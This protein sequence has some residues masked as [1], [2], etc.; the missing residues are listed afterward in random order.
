MCAQLRQ[1]HSSL[2]RKA[3][4][5]LE[6]RSDEGSGQP[7]TSFTVSGQVSWTVGQGQ[8]RA[9]PG[10]TA[11]L[12]PRPGKDR[13]GS[14]LGGHLVHYIDLHPSQESHSAQKTLS[15]SRRPAAL[16]S[17]A[18]NRTRKRGEGGELKR[19]PRTGCRC[20]G[21][22]AGP[23]PSA[24]AGDTTFRVDG[25]PA[26][27]FLIWLRGTPPSLRSASAKPLGPYILD[28]HP[29]AARGAQNVRPPRYL[30]TDIEDGWTSE[31]I[32]VRIDRSTPAR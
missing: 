14:G 22:E 24:A 28:A 23:V 8:T 6:T 29:T 15:R 9:A 17:R 25:V 16:I 20:A 27:Q 10:P 7:N 21:I 19:H 5:P 11:A 12:P 1:A 26:S 3:S 13:G 30:R 18:L 4:C 31:R 2:I 32:Y